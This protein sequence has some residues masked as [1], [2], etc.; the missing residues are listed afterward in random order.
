MFRDLKNS[1]KS[2]LETE[3]VSVSKTIDAIMNT[4]QD[5]EPHDEELLLKRS[6]QLRNYKNLQG[7]LDCLG[8][9]WDYLN[10][11][12][13]AVIISDFSLHSLEGQLAEYQRELDQFMDETPIK[14]FS[15][16]VGSRKQKM[17]PGE[18]TNLVTQHKWDPPVFLRQVEEFRRKVA[19]EYKLRRCAVFIVGLGYGSVII[20]LV[21]PD[22]TWEELRSTKPEFLMRHGIMKMTYNGISIQVRHTYNDNQE[23]KFQISGVSITFSD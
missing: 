1:I 7:V 16:V 15:Q 3:G 6:E 14:E 10:P 2:E 8:L 22:S 4:P 23:F 18:F 19:S 5:L 13:Y 20:T 17:I 12:I 9:D 11:D 21:V